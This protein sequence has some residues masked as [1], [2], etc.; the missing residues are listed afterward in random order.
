MTKEDPELELLNRRKIYQTIDSFPGIHF[1]ELFRKLDISMGS[2]EY[3]INILEKN[4]LIY[5]KKEGG[6][7]RYFVKGKLGAEDKELASILQNDRARKMLFTL[8]LNPGLTHKM[9][10]ERLA[11]PKSTTSFYLKKLLKKQI[12]EERERTKIGLSSKL[13][14]EKSNKGLFV[15]R[16]DRVIH[17]VTIYKAGFFDEL[18]NRILDLVETI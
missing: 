1:R 4:G 12:V 9:L 3:H 18:A 6:F 13:K 15:V 7:T 14:P 17:L 2:L 8:V 11:W 5:Q 10:T 16:P